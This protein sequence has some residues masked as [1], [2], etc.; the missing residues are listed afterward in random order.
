M[1]KRGMLIVCYVLKMARRKSWSARPT[2]NDNSAA[3]VVGGVWLHLEMKAGVEMVA[4][5][6]APKGRPGDL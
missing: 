5:I 1:V 3:A 2:A 4:L 6:D